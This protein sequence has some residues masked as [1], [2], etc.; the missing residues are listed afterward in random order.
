[1]KQLSIEELRFYS[2]ELIRELGFLENPYERWD[3]NFLQVHLLLECERHGSIDQQKLT[4]ILRVDKSYVSRMVKVLIKK[5][6]IALLDPPSDNRSKPVMLTAAGHL[7]VAEINYIANQQVRSAIH[8][9]SQE[10]QGK[11]AEGLRLYSQAF[12]K[13]RHLEGVIIRPVEKKD[14]AALSA[15]IK[16]TLI[17]FGANKPGFAFTDEETNAIFESYQGPGRG[18]FVA[19]KSNSIIGGIGYGSLLGTESTYCELRKMYIIK[20]VRGI[21]LGDEL[22][23]FIQKEAK[24]FY[25]VMYLETLSS[26]TQAISLYRR[27][28]FEFLKKPKGNTGH[29]S[30]DTWMEKTL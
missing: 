17:E 30:C 26:M 12:K 24:K 1:M 8:Y 10:E 23:H 25:Q 6:L 11:I 16:T 21:G 18:Y 28:Q 2:R 9:L 4:K 13:A 29:F 22:L 27:H 15:L 20:E 3:L 19:E 5:G 14:N 7:S